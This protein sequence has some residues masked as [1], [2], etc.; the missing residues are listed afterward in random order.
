MSHLSEE[1]DSNIRDTKWI[2]IFLRGIISSEFNVRAIRLKCSDS[3]QACELGG[4]HDLALMVKDSFPVP[5]STEQQK[6]CLWGLSGSPWNKRT[7]LAN[8]K[9]QCPHCCSERV[10]NRGLWD[11]EQEGWSGH[12][13]AKPQDSCS[14][15]LARMTCALPQG[16]SDW[17]TVPSSSQIQG[18]PLPPTDSSQLEASGCPRRCQKS[19]SAFSVSISTTLMPMK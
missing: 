2:F 5:Q 7:L 3:F 19:S 14:P 1:I 8:A 15:L 16:E 18:P 10:R 9:C 4:H 12:T 6:Q 11:P 17:C 13:G